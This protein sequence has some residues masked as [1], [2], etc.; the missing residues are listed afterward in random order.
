MKIKKSTTAKRQ[1]WRIKKYFFFKV[2]EENRV[3]NA[4]TRTS[5]RR[6]QSQ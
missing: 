2:K 4:F 5:S 1:R 3:P 6:G